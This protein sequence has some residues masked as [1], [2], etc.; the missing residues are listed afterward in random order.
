M[1]GSSHLCL[2]K[3]L[4]Y[5]AVLR[6][7]EWHLFWVLGN[8]GLRPDSVTNWWLWTIHLTNL[9]FFF[10]VL[11][12]CNA[13]P[14]ATEYHLTL[15]ALRKLIPSTSSTPSSFSCSKFWL[16]QYQSLCSIAPIVS[17]PGMLFLS[18]LPYSVHVSDQRPRAFRKFSLASSRDRLNASSILHIWHH[19]EMKICMYLLV[20]GGQKTFSGQET[21]F[22]KVLCWEQVWHRQEAERGPVWLQCSEWGSRVVQWVWKDG[23]NQAEHC[24]PQ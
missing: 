11:R 4:G 7:M 17:L 19:W 12:P 23:Q 8:W 13:L 3:P 14:Q 24:R 16:Q 1:V 15:L 20:E 9:L 21:G 6:L 10:P 18:S 22:A 5:C 2:N